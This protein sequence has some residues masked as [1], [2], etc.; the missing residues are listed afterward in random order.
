[1]ES[2]KSLVDCKSNEAGWLV[3]ETPANQ[4]GVH[5]EFI[6]K[7]YTDEKIFASEDSLRPRSQL[8]I[9]KA[10]LKLAAKNEDSSSQ[11]SSV[12]DK[13][14]LIDTDSPKAVLE[15]ISKKES[16][17][18]VSYSK[19][20]KLAVNLVS[21][22]EI[23]VADEK[24]SFDN[25]LSEYQKPVSQDLAKNLVSAQKSPQYGSFDSGNEQLVEE[26][27]LIPRTKKRKHIDDKKKTEEKPQKIK[28]NN[29]SKIFNSFFQNEHKVTIMKIILCKLFLTIYKVK[30]IFY[31]KN[32]K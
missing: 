11:Y 9:T 4:P 7:H 13:N 5:R 20:E 23:Q 32:F 24:F 31:Y 16:S 28:K 10:L 21:Q 18:C 19:D 27:A 26:N 12:T 2:K 8:R 1:M 15:S 22:T 3:D 6:L 14:A 25:F 17:L 29:Q 30:Y